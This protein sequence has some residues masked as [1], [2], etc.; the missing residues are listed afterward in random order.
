[1]VIFVTNCYKHLGECGVHSSF[2]MFL[3]TTPRLS[4]KSNDVFVHCCDIVSCLWTY[5][6]VPK[7]SSS[8]PNQ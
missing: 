6:K 2:V 4:L 7:L 3:A 5:T 1:M 8:V